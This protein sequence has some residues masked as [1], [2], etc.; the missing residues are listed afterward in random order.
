MCYKP[1][2][3]TCDQS[4]GLTE[5]DRLRDFGSTECPQRSIQVRLP[6][7]WGDARQVT[8]IWHHFQKYGELVKQ[9]EPPGWKQEAKLLPTGGTGLSLNPPSTHCQCPGLQ[10]LS[11][12]LPPS[13]LQRDPAPYPMHPLAPIPRGPFG[14]RQLSPV[15]VIDLISVY[16]TVSLICCV[17]GILIHLS[18]QGADNATLLCSSSDISLP[19]SPSV[20]GAGHYFPDFPLLRPDVTPTASPLMVMATAPCSLG[21]GKVSQSTESWL[22]RTTE[23][24]KKR[25][26]GRGKAA[27]GPWGLL[28]PNTASWWG[29]ALA[30]S[31]KL[32]IAASQTH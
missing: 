21:F 11:M 10:S 16:F 22:R 32:K 17:N 9:G 19:P 29:Q 8:S 2:Q 5:Q 24:R 30:G 18:L 26:P 7:E 28:S 25:G 13:P 23:P 27:S 12:S 6:K 20:G 14:K 31:S 4:V 1:G 15:L 3:G